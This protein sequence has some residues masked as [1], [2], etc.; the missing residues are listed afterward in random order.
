MKR[1]IVVDV[2]FRKSVALLFALA[3]GAAAMAEPA[4]PIK[5]TG[6]P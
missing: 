1:R 4:R 5:W 6:P 3:V 2:F